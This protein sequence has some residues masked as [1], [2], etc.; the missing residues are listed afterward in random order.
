MIADNKKNFPENPHIVFMGTPDFSVPCLR[1]LINSGH[2][3]RA[4]VTQPDRPSGRGRKVVSSPVKDVA[5][6]K[7]LKVF[8]PDTVNSPDFADL[9]KSLEPDIFVVIAFGQLLKKELLNIPTFGAL[10]I[11]ASLLPSYRGA[12]PIHH[13]VL[14]D[15][16]TTGLTIMRM[17]QGMDTGP[18]LFQKRV[19]VLENECFGSLY[20]RLS[21]YAGEIIT[22]FLD[23]NGGKIIE[24]Q[25]QDDSMATYAPKLDS[26]CAMIDWSK[27]A[28]EISG[29]IRALD[30]RPGAWSMLN[31]EKIKLYSSGI[32]NSEDRGSAPGRIHMEESILMV[33]TGRGTVAIGE[34]QLP[35]KKRICIKDFLNGHKI[36]EGSVFGK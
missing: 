12:A 5:L 22:Q 31:G 15:D 28:V 2:E 6:E 17:N 1:A 18:V 10:N 25:P 21:L 9:L 11:H 13:T 23:E 7:N 34:I 24:E 36:P 29:L 19:K 32:H 3:I 27:T 14:N 35:G 33:E 16:S 8:Q 4:V 20:N 30:P 26:E